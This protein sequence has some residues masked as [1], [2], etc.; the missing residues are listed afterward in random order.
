MK[1]LPKLPSTFKDPITDYPPVN[2]VQ[3]SG[4]LGLFHQL[5]R[6]EWLRVPLLF[7]DNSPA[8]KTADEILGRAV[9]CSEYQ[10]FYNSESEIN[11]WGAMPADLICLSEDKKTVVLL[12]NKIGSR[13]TG[14]RGDP[15][16]GQLAKQADFLFHCQ[17]PRAFL[18]I[19]S[20]KKCFDAGLYRNEL[21]SAL[22]NCGRSPKV[23]GY[24]MRWEDVLSALC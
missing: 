8:G 20:T 16:T 14:T 5:H 9:I 24:L 17:I 13:F 23:A 1:K 3:M 7:P 11:I 6:V 21:S 19:L 10:L 4:L 22:Q 12:E 15:I 18:V 2:E